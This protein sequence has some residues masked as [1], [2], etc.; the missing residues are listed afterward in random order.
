MCYHGPAGELQLGDNCFQSFLAHLLA[1]DGNAG[2]V[3]F[4]QPK[5]GLVEDSRNGSF[6]DVYLIQ[7]LQ[8]QSVKR[9]QR[10]RPYQKALE[11]V[12]NFCIGRD[13]RDLTLGLHPVLRGR[14]GNM[15]LS[16]RCKV[17]LQC[18]TLWPYLVEYGKMQCST[19]SQ[20]SPF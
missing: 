17:R 13:S 12:P 20:K 9:S 7:N 11:R 15:S 10:S 5:Q 16:A 3:R 18:S 14:G 8:T 6:H 4:E 19:L 2:V 1:A